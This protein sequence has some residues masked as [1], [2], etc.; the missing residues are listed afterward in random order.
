VVEE[1]NARG[2]QVPVEIVE[3]H[4][5]CSRCLAR[6][7]NLGLKEDY[8]WTDNAQH[9]V[10]FH[11]VSCSC[12]AVTVVHLLE[13]TRSVNF[14]LP[15]LTELWPFVMFECV[16]ESEQGRDSSWNVA[17]VSFREEDEVYF[18]IARTPYLEMNNCY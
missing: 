10:G 16:K 9:V 15:T 2:I 17:Y 13:F 5:K 3:S 18:D 4:K 6:G 1:Y 12:C 7:P 8:L 14:G 11:T